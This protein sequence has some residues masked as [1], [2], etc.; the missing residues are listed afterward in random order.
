MVEAGAVPHEPRLLLWA[1]KGYKQQRE[2]KWRIT[3][4]AGPVEE[5]SNNRNTFSGY[6]WRAEKY[7]DFTDT[8]LGLS[9]GVCLCLGEWHSTAGLLLSFLPCTQDKACHW[10]H[11]EPST[12]LTCLL[13]RLL[14]GSTSLGPERPIPYAW[15]ILLNNQ[16]FFPY[17]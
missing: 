3:R 7:F 1:K 5:S 15:D 2:S 4:L 8:K 10:E 17:F 12:T 11:C 16:E 14:L 6:F 9:S 13:I